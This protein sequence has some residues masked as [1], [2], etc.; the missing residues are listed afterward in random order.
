VLVF[1]RKEESID[2]VS[3]IDTEGFNIY[4]VLQSALLQSFTSHQLSL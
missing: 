4:I 1:D 2:E 3:P